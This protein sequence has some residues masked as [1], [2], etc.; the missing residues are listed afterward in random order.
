[1]ELEKWEELR[2][3]HGQSDYSQYSLI[4]TKLSASEQQIIMNYNNLKKVIENMENMI[5]GL[6]KMFEKITANELNSIVKRIPSEIKTIVK[7]LES[8]RG[9]I[10]KDQE[11]IK[12]SPIFIENMLQKTGQS[13]EKTSEKDNLIK[14]DELLNGFVNNEIMESRKRG[15]RK[16][17]IARRR[18][19]WKR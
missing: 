13:I 15:D 17:E 1:M 7:N 9:I 5:S 16:S 10:I 11:K 4:L 18:Q 19:T 3:R 12:L 2:T 6:V 14:V 8:E